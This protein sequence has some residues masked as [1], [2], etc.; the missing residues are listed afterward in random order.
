MCIR[1]RYTSMLAGRN[2]EFTCELYRSVIRDLYRSFSQ[3]NEEELCIK[4]THRLSFKERLFCRNRLTY[5]C[6]HNFPVFTKSPTTVSRTFKGNILFFTY[7]KIYYTPVQMFTSAKSAYTEL[8]YHGI[9]FNFIL[10][11]RHCIKFNLIL[12][13]IH[14]YLVKCTKQ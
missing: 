4:I 10:Y 8:R 13:V 7:I 11:S 9:L 5:F 6:L 12:C 1:D 2:Q 14:T 3:I